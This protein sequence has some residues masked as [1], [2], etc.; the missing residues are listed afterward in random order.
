MDPFN[1]IILQEVSKKLRALTSQNI[2]E[3]KKRRD[4]LIELSKKP[5]D[6]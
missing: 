1:S 2:E 3:P 6:K 5:N 4:L